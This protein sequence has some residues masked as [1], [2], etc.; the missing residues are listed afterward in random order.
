MTDLDLMVI[1]ALVTFLAVAGAYIAIRHRANEDPVDSYAP[2]PFA[3]RAA[4]NGHA[5][6]QPHVMHAQERSD[7][8]A[9]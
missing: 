1:G 4:Q 2:A 5:A 8:H 9:N 3:S 6:R 7:Y